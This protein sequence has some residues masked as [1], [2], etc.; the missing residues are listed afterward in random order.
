[1][2]RPPSAGPAIAATCQALVFQVTADSKS[3]RGTTWGR[4]AHRAGRFSAWPTPVTTRNRYVKPTGPRRAE[5]KARPTVA[6]RS[7]A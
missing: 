1:M 5:S 7:N 3:S 2:T 6:S 4:I